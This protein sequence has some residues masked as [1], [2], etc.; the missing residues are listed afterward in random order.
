[1]LFSPS[2]RKIQNE[3][4]TEV[5]WKRKKRAVDLEGLVQTSVTLGYEAD[6]WGTERIALDGVQNHLPADSKGTRVEV[7]FLVNGKWVSRTDYMNGQ[8]VEAIRFSDDGVGYSHE[9]LGIF[10]STKKGNADAVGYF[11]EGLKMLSA[12]CLREGI[13]LE[14]RSRN[15][16]ARPRAIDLKIDDQEIQRLAYEVKDGERIKGSQSIFWNPSPELVDYISRLDGKV[17]H[18]RKGFQ[19]LYE[20]GKRAILDEEGDMFVK[21]IYISS[22]FKDRL[23]FSYSLDVTP[24]RDR[25]DIHESVLVDELTKIWSSCDTTAPIKALLKASEG[26]PERF[27]TTHEAYVL[28]RYADNFKKE[29]WQKAFT[30]LYGDNAVLQT[31]K[32]IEQIVE[33]LGHRVVSIKDPL[34]RKALRT[35]G[36]KADIETMEAGDNLLYQSE[37]FEPNLIQRDVK[38]TSLT[39]DYRASNWGALRIVL[40]A[41]GNH[42]PNDSGG[43]EVVIEYLLIKRDDKGN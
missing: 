8:Q 19:P 36:V 26:D 37:S 35:L 23:L 14:L 24:N 6:K 9:M 29:T 30:E 33:S 34:L 31:Q 42:M 3:F 7:D 27:S 18:L 5:V 12:A 10:H 17:L 28:K 22:L 15:W 40:D 38:F 32:N 41:L 4:P 16:Q 21:G 11:G 39:L 1:M 43:S 20:S 13:D 2:W 25:D